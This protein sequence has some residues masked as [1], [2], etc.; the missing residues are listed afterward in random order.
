MLR[1]FAMY[2][3]SCGRDVKLQ[4][5]GPA[6]DEEYSSQMLSLTTE[7]E[8]L[9]TVSFLGPRSDVPEL[10][11]GADAFL[12]TPFAE[13]FGLSV[14]EGAAAGLPM[15][16]SDLETIRAYMGEVPLYFSPGDPHSLAGALHC[17]DASWVTRTRIADEAAPRVAER[18]SIAAC[19]K[20]Y[21]DVFMLASQCA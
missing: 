5:A 20:A 10:L 1:G 21:L 2:R 15:V 14:A 11:A 19:A 6:S 7:L 13:A 17:L 3:S 12:H 8:L 4:I 16:V 18:Y 9:D